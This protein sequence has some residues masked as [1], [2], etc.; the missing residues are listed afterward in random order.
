MLVCSRARVPRYRKE[1]ENTGVPG[2]VRRT[3]LRV[4]LNGNT[5]DQVQAAHTPSNKHVK[6]QHLE[7]FVLWSWS[8]NVLRTTKV[9]EILH[10]ASFLLAIYL[11]LLPIQAVNR[12][13]IC[14]NL[15]LVFK[16]LNDFRSTEWTMRFCVKFHFSYSKLTERKYEDGYSRHRNRRTPAMVRRKL[17]NVGTR[18][19]RNKFE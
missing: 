17:C 15:K 1:N 2:R 6:P 4:T 19:W 18:L 11:L 13:C 14:F 9:W 10:P 16:P 7:I 12:K 5:R 3:L 8:E